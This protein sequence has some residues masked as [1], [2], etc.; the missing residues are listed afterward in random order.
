MY[1]DQAKYIDSDYATMDMIALG[2]AEIAKYGLT[3]KAAEILRNEHIKLSDRFEE[4]KQNGEH[5][6]WFFLG[7]SYKMHSFLFRTMFTTFMFEA[8]ILIVLATALL[9]TYEFENRTHLVAYSTKRGR[10]LMKDKLAASLLTALAITTFLLIVML[11]T[12]FTVFDYS[13][14]WG[15]SISSAFNWEYNMPY[16]TWWEMPFLKFLLLVIVLMYSCMLLFSAIAFVISI[17]VKNSYF[18]FF[19]FAIFFAIGFMLPS[20]MP[21]SSSLIFITG[22][23]L[24]VVVMNPH[25]LFTGSS[26][27]VMFKYHE[28]VTMTVWTIIV[29]ACYLLVTKYFKRVDIQ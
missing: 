6:E 12:Y 3:G 16:I 21:S 23:N 8:L 4:L 11:G 14:V 25:M 9:T 7:K 28:L 13:H 15:S 20:F 1:L 18:T 17:L 5:K 29:V 26:G 10:S 19:I 24:S 2:E 22:F 27:L